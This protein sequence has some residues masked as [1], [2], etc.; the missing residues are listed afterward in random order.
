MDQ[1]CG[2]EMKIKSFIK[3]L[4]TIE[5]KYGDIEIGLFDDSTM[6]FGSFVSMV[7]D[8]D[9]NNK[10]VGF[11]SELDAKDYID[12]RLNKTGSPPSRRKA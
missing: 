11:F 8:D 2:E 10:C 1:A 3:Q 6:G 9:K 4:E 5:R 12:Q 7:M